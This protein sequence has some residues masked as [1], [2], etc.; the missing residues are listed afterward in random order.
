MAKPPPPDQKSLVGYTI[1][2]C[3]LLRICGRG[4]MGTVYKGVHGGLDI[5]VAVKVLPPHLADNRNLVERFMRE[6]KLAARLNHVNTVRVY[7]VGEESG[8]YYL[9]MEFIDGTDALELVKRH[10]KQL[11][12]VVADIGAGASLALEHAHQK[13]VI[14]R[15]IK[16]ANL[17]LPNGGGVKVGDFGLARALA[18]ESGL[19][20]DGAVMGTPDYMA[21]EQAQ[22][23]NVGPSA[24][25]YSLG[26][27]LYHMFVGRAPFSGASPMAVALQ[28]VT[29]RIVVPEEMSQDES[30]SGL[31]RLIHELTQKDP[32]QRPKDLGA[33]ARR[34]RDIAVKGRG[35]QKLLSEGATL[36]A[37]AGF[38]MDAEAINREK[39]KEARMKLRED[40]QVESPHLDKLR[41]AARKA[42]SGVHPGAPPRPV[43]GEMGELTG[44]MVREARAK[45]RRSSGQLKSLGPNAERKGTRRQSSPEMSPHRQPRPT[46]DSR[47]N[48]LV[49]SPEHGD[50]AWQ[51]YAAKSFPTFEKKSIMDGS[52]RKVAAQDQASSI[53]SSS[54]ILE[55]SSPAHDFSKPTVIHGPTA[56]PKKGGAGAAGVVLALL[57]VG[58]VAVGVWYFAIRE[59]GRTAPSVDDP[60]ATIFTV[61]RAVSHPGGEPV[62]AIAADP[63]TGAYFTGS[64]GGLIA[65]WEPG[66]EGPVATRQLEGVAVSALA[67]RPDGRRLA[68]GTTGGTVMLLGRSDLSVYRSRDVQVTGEVTALTAI[69]VAGMVVG[70]N[71]GRVSL[72]DRHVT[73][74]PSGEPVTGLLYHGGEVWAA[75]GHTVARY[76][77][78][79]GRLEVVTAYSGLPGKATAIAATRY[80]VFAMIGRE[81]HEM[82][83]TGPSRR[84]FN[85]GADVLGAT[86]DGRYLFT[87]GTEGVAVLDPNDLSVRWTREVD[88]ADAVIS[89]GA[90][91]VPGT[92][93]LGTVRGIV[94]S[95]AIR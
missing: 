78:S 52:A 10:G 87:M 28:H 2:R 71:R 39:S 35:S 24:D 90:G 64:A 29:N 42:R 12:S 83:E 73:V 40:K 92:F 70:D 91:G 51:S 30:S 66:I 48:R 59:E 86:D 36:Y 19:T 61:E 65:R 89:V 31:T 53:R 16:P 60:L 15:D 1:G 18:S 79:Q 37:A 81:V 23:E 88:A 3:K 43:A 77:I 54:D 80:G 5:E 49:Q 11:P 55:G 34:L 25:V 76:R 46:S 95:C 32:K 20:M 38:T 13:D 93:Y 94:Y 21:P 14:H 72:G 84:S 63:R 26:A 44:D 8:Y 58:A 33:V 57:I 6:G 74:D 22:G 68:V 27:T 50:D 47:R 85:A 62:T 17:M 69:G 45:A 9:V 56:K 7:D 75:A 41:D 4:A 67:P 82:L